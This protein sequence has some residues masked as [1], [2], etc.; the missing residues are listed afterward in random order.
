[1]SLSPFFIY[2]FK[3]NGTAHTN[4][5][6]ECPEPRLYCIRSPGRVVFFFLNVGYET[7][8]NHKI[9]AVIGII[10][11]TCWHDWPGSYNSTGHNLG[12]GKY[13]PVHQ[14]MWANMSPSENTKKFFFN[15]L[16]ISAVLGDFPWPESTQ[17]EDHRDV[18]DS[19][20]NLAISSDAQLGLSIAGISSHWKEGNVGIAMSFAPSP[21]HHHI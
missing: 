17:E 10:L 20:C 11:R 21:I 9:L 1:M 7:W 14:S 13:G 19:S 18:Q 12:W 5:D 8:H 4:L 2:A 3:Y 6:V 15:I 16:H